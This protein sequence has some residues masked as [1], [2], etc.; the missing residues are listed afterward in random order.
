[1]LEQ[2]CE[3]LAFVGSGLDASCLEEVLEEAFWERD[4]ELDIGRGS[5]EDGS[6]IG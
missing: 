6:P 2:V 1:V 3:E 5:F 4:Q